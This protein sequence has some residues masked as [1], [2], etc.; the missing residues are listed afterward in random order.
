MTRLTTH[1]L[2][3]ALALGALS[4][5]SASAQRPI[6]VSIESD[7]PGA[8]VYFNV[9]DESKRIGVTPLSNVRIPRGQHVLI[10]RKEMHEETRLTVNVRRRRE[11]FRATLN[12]QSTISISGTNTPA[13]GAAVRIDGE[14]VGNV[15]HMET[16]QPGRHLVQVGREG[17]VTFSQWVQVGPAQGIQVTVSLEEEAAETGSLLVAGDT[18]GAAI[19][20]D[21][22]PRGT[23]PSV[24]EGITAGEHTVKVQADDPDMEVFEQ[25][26]RIIAGERVTINPTLR[27]APAATGS[28]RVLVR[29]ASAEGAVV[30]LDGEVLGEAPASK[31]N[32]TPGEHIIEVR[33][34]GFE[35]AQQ[36]VNIE[37]GTQRVVSVELTPVQA[38]MGRIVINANV[39]GASVTVDGEDKGAPPVVIEE[40]SAGT[41]AIVVRAPGYQELRHTCTTGPGQSCE[42]VADMEPVGSRVRVEANVDNAEFVVDGEPMGRVPWEGTIP[43][44]FHDIE[45]RADGYRTYHARLEFTE[46]PRLINEGLVREGQMTAEERPEQEADLRRRHRQSV[47]RSGAPL[48]PDVA[49]LDFSVGWPYLL[50]LRMGI[51]ILDWLDAGIGIRSFFRLTEFEGRVKA[52]FRPVKQVSLGA[53]LRVGGGIG[54]GRDDPL[55]IDESGEVLAPSDR[56]MGAPQAMGIVEQSTNSFFFS[57]EALFTLHF[58]RAGNFTLWGALDYHSESWAWNGSNNNCRFALG[59]QPDNSIAPGDPDRARDPDPDSAENTVINERQSLARFRLGGSLEFILSRHWNMWVSFEGTFGGD[60]R[61]V[62]DLFGAGRS[63]IN[64]YTRVGFTYK[65]GYGEELQ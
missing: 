17:Y 53:M 50:E 49:V 29:P 14:P 3:L 39:A 22:D 56:A 46:E 61:I 19:Y 20:I 16:V 51:G 64:A 47:A 58:L 55:T 10:F 41:H 36:P 11:T 34:E 37:S 9:V 33:A 59:C 45:I 63:D 21:G 23:T 35:G 8:T 15:P 13:Q 52:G 24:I 48:D 42:L 65:F 31:E 7:P 26:V 6:P 25:R 1:G 2:A 5:S 57:L 28:L 43:V 32:V 40:P 38:A 27:P 18:T 30:S 54:V 62:G 4:A 12:A 60:R 44:G